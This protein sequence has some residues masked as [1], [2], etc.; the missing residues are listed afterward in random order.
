MFTLFKKRIATDTSSQAIS[1]ITDILEANSIKYEIRTRRP[2]GSVG[3]AL[4]SRS[5]AGAN[6]AMYK[7]AS[8]PTYVYMLYVKRRDYQRARELVFGS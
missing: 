3:T 5:Y 7:G 6:I 8:Q 2:R 1:R 4:D